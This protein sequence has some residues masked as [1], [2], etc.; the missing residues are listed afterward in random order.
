MNEWYDAPVSL[1]H[2]VGEERAKAFAGLGIETVGELLEYFPSRYEDYR[3]RDLTEVKD[4][5]RVTLAGTV[6]GEPSVR[7]YGKR[8]SRISVKLVMDR[9]VVTAVW[10]NQ[11]FVKSRL[12]PGKE[13]LVTGKWDKHKLQITVSEMT[14]T[15]SDRAQKR[16]ELAP[17]YP[18]GGDVTHTLLR[19]TIQ[20]ALRQ[21][22][23]QIPEILP[24]DIVSRYRLMPRPDAIR[25]IHFPQDAE[26]GRQARRR[27]MFEELFLFQLKMQAL[28]RIAREQTEGTALQIPMEE[29]RTFVKSLPFPLTDAQKRVIKEILTDMRSPYAMNRLL[30]GDVGSG[31][32][33]VAAIALFAAVKA[34]FQGALMVPTEILA[35]QHV[36]SLTGLLSPHG[37]Q[38]ALLS[39]SLT[40]KRRREVIGALQMGLIDVVVGTHA[41]IQE[42][43][44][45]SKLGLV[46]TDEQHRFGV[47]QRRILRNKGLTPDVLF[48][49]ATPIP[50]TL[51]ISAFGDM[52]VSTIDQMPAGRKPIETTWKKHEQ[53]HQVLEQMREELVKGR[54][55]Y[56]ICPLIEESEKLDV[57]NAIDVHAQLSQVFPEY[58]VGLMHGRLP[59]KEKDAVMQAFLS[60][61]YAVLVSTTV[62]EVGVNVP[63]AT[64]M[65]IYDA[66]RFGLA[67]LHQLRGR[68]GRGSEQ[69]Y[70]VLIAD[71]KS[72]IGKERMRVMCE[73]TDGFELSRRDL[74]LRGPGDFF[75]TKQSGLPEFKVADLMSDFK[76]LEVARQ[77][78]AALVEKEE[79][80]K[81]KEYV[82]LRSYLKREGILD[83]IVFD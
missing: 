59:A 41:L 26:N 32:T 7:F 37:I 77:E 79:F 4:G 53:F 65:I 66:E 14:E 23:E 71:P 8:K 47:E 39:G 73:T 78:T 50:R 58:G 82:W 15:D 45:F 81:N 31:K 38:V 3:V 42:D 11:T 75:G 34:G 33:V 57:Q 16:G 18:L 70:C 49:T 56:V 44:F 22:G 74:E 60:G 67:Q 63:N 5:E 52:D 1:L 46:I 64:F 24:T 51:A 27:I 25:S 2:G 21:Y 13:I 83:G 20:Q 30:Q 62:V 43:V 6:Y 36:Q 76:A 80:W 54:Q 69:S 12:S 68:V 29:L 17:I 40:A 10:F 48:M 61:E 19:K 35:E 55:A 28:R 9:V 72:E